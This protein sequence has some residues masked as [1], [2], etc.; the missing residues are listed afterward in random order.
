MG[1]LHRHCPG[2]NAWNWNSCVSKFMVV[3]SR[4][5]RHLFPLE[6]FHSTVFLPLGSTVQ[7]RAACSV[8]EKTLF[9]TVLCPVTP[10]TS[11]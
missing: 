6:T 7:G 4:Q 9:G 8:S 2:Q 10:L 3:H 1:L 5:H 11:G